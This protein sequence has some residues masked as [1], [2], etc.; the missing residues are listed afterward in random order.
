MGILIKMNWRDC[1]VRSE[2]R[3]SFGRIS[4]ASKRVCQGMGVD[5]WGGF[6]RQL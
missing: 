3:N 1:G 5:A 4:F 2:Q 6:A